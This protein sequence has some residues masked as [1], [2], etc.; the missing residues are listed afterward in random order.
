MKVLVIPE[1]PRLD[2]YVL[3][4]ILEAML[5]KL[6]R[7]RST[8]RVC[9]DP[10]L[11][12]V[13]QATNW[14]RISE[15]LDL[16]RGMVDLFLLIVDRDGHAGRRVALDSIEQKAREFLPPGRHLL[17]ENAWQEIEVWVLAGL[18]LPSDWS[19]QAVRAEVQAKEAYFTPFARTRKLLEEPGEGRK[20]LAVEAARRYDR[21]RKLCPEDVASLE[22]R[23]GRVLAPSGLIREATAPWNE[24]TTPSEESV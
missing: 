5:E 15:I 20:R 6:G 2:Q 21:I 13:D 11:G 19:W 1:D 8:V 14:S 23:I 3:K 7:S 9:Q 12:G 10:V 4:P 16:Y 24:P 18:D 17:A 22:D